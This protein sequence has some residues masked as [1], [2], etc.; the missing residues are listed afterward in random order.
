MATA[1]LQLRTS[2]RNTICCTCTVIFRHAVVFC[3]MKSLNLLNCPFSGL[4]RSPI[5]P[6]NNYMRMHTVHNLHCF[7]IC[8]YMFSLSFISLLYTRVRILAQKLRQY[9]TVICFS[10]GDQLGACFLPACECIGRRG[11]GAKEHSIMCGPTIWTLPYREEQY[12]VRSSTGL[13]VKNVFFK[14]H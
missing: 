8:L 5:R 11:R 10:Q 2:V 1:H 13:T 3:K 9:Y 7:V 14:F 4:D 6:S 12:R